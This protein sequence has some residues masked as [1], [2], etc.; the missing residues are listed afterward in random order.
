MLVPMV[1][2]GV[3][4]VQQFQQDTKAQKRILIPADGKE[5]GSACYPWMQEGEL[6]CLGH[7]GPPMDTRDLL[8]AINNQRSRERA[9]FSQIS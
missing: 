1:A 2:K 8:F 4:H 3:V 9:F 5:G 6:A 7:Q